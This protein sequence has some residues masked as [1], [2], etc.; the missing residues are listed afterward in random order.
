MEAAAE[1]ISEEWRII[2]CANLWSF[3]FPN[4]SWD[5]VIPDANC[6]SGGK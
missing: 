1:T 4:G 3:C 2:V 5:A 6:R